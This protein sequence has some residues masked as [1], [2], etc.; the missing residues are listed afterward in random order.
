[1]EALYVFLLQETKLDQEALCNLVSRLW[2]VG[3]VVVVGAIGMVG[4]LEVLWDKLSFSGKNLFSSEN[5]LSVGLKPSQGGGSFLLTNVHDPNL[6][7]DRV[8]C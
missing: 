4:G 3:E 7:R 6:E 5:L 8:G 1:V 2:K